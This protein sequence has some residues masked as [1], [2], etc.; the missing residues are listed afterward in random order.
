MTTPGSSAYLKAALPAGY[1]EKSQ[2]TCPESWCCILTCSHTQSWHAL[3]LA[4]PCW[5][6]A[7]SL[8][9]LGPSVQQLVMVLA[10][11]ETVWMK[12]ESP[13]DVPQ[14]CGINPTPGERWS[15]A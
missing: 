9:C 15:V 7:H 10:W 14:L 8:L 12:A 13:P 1:S 3:P 5:A 2:L 6:P 11:L 4:V